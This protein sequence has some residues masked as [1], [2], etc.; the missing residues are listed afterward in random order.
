MTAEPNVISLARLAI[1]RWESTD[2]CPRVTATSCACAWVC[3]DCKRA[4]PPTVGSVSTGDYGER[5]RVECG[6]RKGIK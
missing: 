1:K 3:P 6:M 4:M 2:E 5:R